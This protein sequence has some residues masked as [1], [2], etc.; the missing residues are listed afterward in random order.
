MNDVLDLSPRQEV[1]GDGRDCQQYCNGDH[2]YTASDMQQTV[3]IRAEASRQAWAAQNS[4]VFLPQAFDLAF[5][6]LDQSVLS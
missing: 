5:V 2:K 3:H 6:S 4:A 1:L